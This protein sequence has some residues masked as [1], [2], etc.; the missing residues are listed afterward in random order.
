MVFFIGGFKISAQ[1][2][3]QK[4]KLEQSSIENLSKEQLL[5]L[6]EQ[7]ELIKANRARFK[8]GLTSKQ[9]TILGNQKMSKQERQK[10]LMLTFTKSQQLMLQEH[11]LSVQEMKDRF[12][13]TLTDEQRHNIRTRMR[14]HKDTQDGNELRETVRDTRRHKKR[15]TN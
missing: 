15:R 6:N 3:K 4:E 13:M 8:A 5:L 9:L 14:I 2:N 1:E 12:R 7:K 11:R 10:S